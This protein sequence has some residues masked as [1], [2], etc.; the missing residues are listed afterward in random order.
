MGSALRQT[1]RLVKC[2]QIESYRAI[3]AILD[4]HWCHVLLTE[5]IHVFPENDRTSLPEDTVHMQEL[6]RL[7]YNDDHRRPHYRHPPGEIKK[8]ANDFVVKLS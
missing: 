1:P 3:E 6:R 5:D 2:F 4:P 7:H 8:T